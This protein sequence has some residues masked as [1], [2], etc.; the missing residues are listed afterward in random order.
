MS[1]AGNVLKEM[2][3][4]ELATKSGINLDILE[5]ECSDSDL[6]ALSD[7]C[8]PWELTARHLLL[9]DP[10]ISDIDSECRTTE[11][12]R[13]AS[14]KK[15]KETKAFGATFRV[16]V[17]ALIAC[18]CV[19]KAREVCEYLRTKHVNNPAIVSQGSEVTFRSPETD[20]SVHSQ[21]SSG[22]NHEQISQLRTAKEK[23][24]SDQTSR[25]RF[26]SCE[27]L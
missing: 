17:D 10:Q 22:Q 8:H 18:K 25:Y 7:F 3:T 24:H 11:E 9:T 2:T 6:L 21:Q 27:H 1:W 20:P 4:Q 26:Y 14:L 12:K 5:Q 15:W 16:F 19:Q 23:L 13:L